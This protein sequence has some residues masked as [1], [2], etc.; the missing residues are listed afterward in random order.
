MDNYIQDNEIQIE[1]PNNLIFPDCGISAIKKELLLTSSEYELAKSA[2]NNGKRKAQIRLNRTISM[3]KRLCTNIDKNNIDLSLYKMEH[4]KPQKFYPLD[5][6]DIEIETLIY[7]LEH[8]KG[9]KS[10]ETQKLIAAL[11]YT[12]E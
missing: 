7:C 9:S 8:S 1:I 2:L 11:K 6:L 3:H 12:L 10:K 4:C 5:L